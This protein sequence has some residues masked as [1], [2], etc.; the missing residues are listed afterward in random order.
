MVTVFSCNSS[1]STL[2]W[3]AGA[4]NALFK[5][6]EEGCREKE[7]ETAQASWT[8][9]LDARLWRC[10][11]G[12]C[13]KRDT[14]A[15]LRDDCLCQLAGSRGIFG[16]VLLRQVLQF[17]DSHDNGFRLEVRHQVLG[18][19][20]ADAALAFLTINRDGMTHVIP[21]LFLRRARL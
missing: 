1:G 4:A 11:A 10:W 16:G 15:S 6:A 7:T 12:R 21:F 5:R 8:S 9:G 2:E 19:W 13:A 3:L 20:A 17:R 18:M 14:V